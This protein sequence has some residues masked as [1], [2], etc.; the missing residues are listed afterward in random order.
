MGFGA[1]A[2]GEAGAGVDGVGVVEG[3]AEFGDRGGV[4]WRGERVEPDVQ[5]VVGVI[6]VIAA[7]PIRRKT[8]TNYIAIGSGIGSDT[9]RISSSQWLH[10]PAKPAMSES[11]PQ[12]YAVGQ[13]ERH[14]D[15]AGLRWWSTLEAS[16]IEV[17]VFD[18]ALPQLSV[19]QVRTLTIDDEAVIAAA[20]HLGLR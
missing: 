16:W 19:H 9:R 3:L 12:A 8:L 20:S 17:T 5:G 10:R 13:F 4:W 18:R 7:P 14:P 15:A 6:T 11:C 2:Q 1:V